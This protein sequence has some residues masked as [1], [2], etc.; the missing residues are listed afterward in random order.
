MR[1][2]T[3]IQIAAPPP[4]VW[5]ILTDTGATSR[6]LPGLET[7]QVLEP[8]KRF[9]LVVAWAANGQ[10]GGIR[11]PVLIEWTELEPPHHLLVQA[12]LQLGS[13]RVPLAST[14]TLQPQP[15][16]ATRLQVAT[17]LDNANPILAGMTQTAVSKIL[18]PFLRCLREQAE[19][20]LLEES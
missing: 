15:P 1:L 16:A 19:R 14:I 9:Q 18:A 6:C 20:R 2:E 10:G 13:N 12:E 17:E 3:S 11:V 7:W 4:V 8:D 5:S